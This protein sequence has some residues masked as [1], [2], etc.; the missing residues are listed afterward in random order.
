MPLKKKKFKLGL[1]LSGG[2]V[3]GFAHVGVL[4]ALNEHGIFP[5]VISGASAGAIAGALY[6]DGKTPDEMLKI[7]EKKS[8][9][10]FL[11]F[12]VP[13]KGLVKMTGLQTALKQSISSKTFEELKI[14]FY[15]AVTDLNNAKSVYFSSGELVNMVIASSTIPILFTPIIIDGV[16]Y[17][18]GAIMNNLPIEPIEDLCEKIIGVNVNYIGHRD[19]FSGMMEMAD[20][21]IHLM[22]DQNVEPKKKK[23]DLFIEPKELNKIGMMEMANHIK[24]FEIGYNET[25]KILKENMHIFK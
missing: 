15:A 8:I 11:E 4:K 21:A 10:K 22:I 17:V 2:A 23:F 12:I 9:Y 14:P 25:N 16:Y 18:D 3:R 6:A 13:N 1:V 7:F 24:I 5:D 19:G 20:R